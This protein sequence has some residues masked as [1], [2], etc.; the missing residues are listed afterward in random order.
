M[1]RKF[2]NCWLEYR[3]PVESMDPPSNMKIGLCWYQM[4]TDNKLTYEVISHL[5][6]DLETII[7]LAS[8]IYIANLNACILH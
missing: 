1:H 7:A 6:I 5:M 4:G 8:I 2:G 3:D